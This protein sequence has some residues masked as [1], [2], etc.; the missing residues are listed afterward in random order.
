MIG[1][2]QVS[3][4]LL[5]VVE[6]KSVDTR[7]VLEEHLETDKVEAESVRLLGVDADEWFDDVVILRVGALTLS[8]RQPPLWTVRSSS[9]SHQHQTIK[10]PRHGAS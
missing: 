6:D 1:S 7:Q 3:S 4:V 8:G 2:I 5:V 10:R 9:P